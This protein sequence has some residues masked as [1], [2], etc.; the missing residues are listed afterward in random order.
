MWFFDLFFLQF[1]FVKEQI[2]PSILESPLD[3]QIMKVD[4]IFIKNIWAQ[5]FKAL[6]A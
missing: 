1:W 6:L 2:A 4:C 5:L 3:F